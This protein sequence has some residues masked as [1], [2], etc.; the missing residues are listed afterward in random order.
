MTHYTEA[1]F[2][3]SFPHNQ[4]FRAIILGIQSHLFQ[5][6]RS[7]PPL[8]LIG[9]QSHSFRHSEPSLLIQ[10][11]R[12]TI[13]GIQSHIFQFQAFKATILG[14]QS[15]F[16]QFIRLESFLSIR[17]SE[18]FLPIQVFNVISFCLVVHSHSFRLSEP[19]LFW[20]S[21]LEPQFWV[22]KPIV[23]GIQSHFFHF[24]HLEPPLSLIGILS[25]NF[26]HSKS[27]IPI[28]AFRVISFSLGVQS[29][30]FQFRHSKSPSSVQAFKATFI[31]Q[32][33]NATLLSQ[34]FRAIFHSLGVQIHL[35]QFRRSKPPSLAQAFR[36]TFL[37]LGVQ[38][39][40]A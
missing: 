30:F 9:I 21:H 1:Y 5:F 16:F 27:S 31:S 39:H 7:E 11:F 13:L 29:H 26:R 12:A 40:L 8:S 4:A 35:A 25:C 34:A 32:T 10:A 15:H 2:L 19:Y 22:F 23:L 33:F 18:S 14:F 17:C 24:I 28:Q 38:S 20:F 6:R 3:S 37:N 36:A